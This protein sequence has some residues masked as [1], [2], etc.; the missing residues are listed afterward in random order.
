MKKINYKSR[1][2]GVLIVIF[3]AVNAFLIFID[4]HDEVDRKSYINEWSKS[5]TYDLY[6]KL[7]A[8]GVFTSQ[9]SNHVYFD[10]DVGAFSEFLVEEGEIIEQGSDLYTYEVI[11]YDQQETQLQ[12]EMD[13]LEEEITAIED[14]IDEIQNYDISDSGSSSFFGNN[15]ND[16]SK[17]HV[18]T[19]FQKE[20]SIAHQAAELT[21]KEAMLEMVEDQLDQL[22][23]DGKTITVTSPFGGVITEVSE[24]LES[25]LIT[26]KSNDL[27]IEGKLNEKERKQVEPGMA[28]N[29]KVEDMD[30][31][32]EG[33]LD[34]IQTFPEDIDVHRSS[35]YPYVI[36]LDD[37]SD[38]ILPGYHAEI[39]IITEE[40]LGAVTALEDLLITDEN[41]YAWVMDRNGLL[42]RREIISGISENGL[43]EIK[44]GLSEGEWLAYQP[45]DEFRNGAPFFTPLKI[46]TLSLKE[47]VD[48]DSTDISRFV[49]M[50]LLAR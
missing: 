34:A 40:S 38:T 11:N 25:P 15:T 35:T 18:R 7:D 24:T 28:A 19:E 16:E 43:V 10:S 6:E 44:E 9:E 45:K 49:M 41:I 8:D 29:I 30:L 4:E 33:T 23:L 22:Q 3:V 13:R 5:I 46:H 31:V 48:S 39:E 1:I 2:I 20:E 37:S 14:Y 47:A 32:W 27:Q 42:E 26:L 36:S 21:K 50:G 17:E 12:S